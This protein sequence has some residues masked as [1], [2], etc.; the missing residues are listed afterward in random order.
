MR[1]TPATILAGTALVIAVLGTSPV[2]NAAWNAVVPKGS[3]GT[4]QLK[5]NAVTT[6]KVKNGSLLKADFKPGQFV[7]GDRVNSSLLQ[8]FSPPSTHP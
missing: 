5:A 2:G 8:V 1:P 4:A 6:A 7:A 3:V